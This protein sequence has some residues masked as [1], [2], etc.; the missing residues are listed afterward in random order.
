MLM[1][2]ERLCCHTSKPALRSTAWCS[3]RGPRPASSWWVRASP[4]QGLTSGCSRT[5]TPASQAWGRWRRRG[6]PLRDQSFVLSDFTEEGEFISALMRTSQHVSLL[7]PRWAAFPPCQISTAENIHSHG[8]KSYN[9]HPTL[10]SSM[11]PPLCQQILW[12]WAL[13]SRT[14]SSSHSTKCLDIPPA[15]GPCSSKA[16]RQMCWK[17]IILEGELWI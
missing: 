13:S 9:P 11:P 7:V 16:L 3:P 2:S 15:W 1:T 17:G 4:G 10:S 8:Y 12:T 14:L 6:E 5:V